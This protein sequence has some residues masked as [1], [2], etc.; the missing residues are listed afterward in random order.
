[1]ACDAP[2]GAIVL[3]GAGNMGGA[4]MN[5]WLDSG[6][7]PGRIVVVDPGPS[8]AMAGRLAAAGIQH[9]DT[10]PSDVAADVLVLAIKPQMMD[11]VLP[12][13][14]PMVGPRTVAV[15]VAAGTPIDRIAGL[16]EG[17]AVVRAMP[18]TPA[19]VGRGIT[20][21]VAGAS[22][23]DAARKEVDG[24]LAVTGPVEWL[25]DEALI[26]AVTAVS[27][28]GPAYVF[29]LVE[30]MAEAG[31][32]EGLPEDLAMRLAR[33]TV[34]GAGEM[35]HRSAQD[36]A[37][38]R[39]NVTSPGGTTAAALAVLMREDAMKRLFAEAVAAARKRAGELAG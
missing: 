19:M 4:L 2:A 21:A 18:N 8:E 27:G 30:C 3:V 7:A 15:S 12:T 9:A 24:L 29:H 32:A 38:L 37:T 16:L 39:A 11:A 22:V 31:R 1:M 34:A 26:D 33:A 6:V 17:C 25:E 20:A 10:V 36:A 23:T 28:S 14:M 5:G 13:L 35:L